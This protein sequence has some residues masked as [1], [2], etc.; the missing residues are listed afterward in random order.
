M[1]LSDAERKKSLEEITKFKKQNEP[2]SSQVKLANLLKPERTR[3]LYGFGGNGG[4]Q[5]LDHLIVT[6]SLL[7][8]S[9]AQKI[10]DTKST[11]KEFD[12]L[13]PGIDLVVTLVIETLTQTLKQHKVRPVVELSIPPH[14]HD[15]YLDDVERLEA[16]KH[17]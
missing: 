6:D 16:S 13:Y 11:I 7:S 5:P 4:S 17:G 9:L 15:L 8:R 2:D 1:G 12:Q 10:W 3:I 14:L